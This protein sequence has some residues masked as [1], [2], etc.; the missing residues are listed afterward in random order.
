[1]TGGG[2]RLLA[3]TV[4]ARRER[5]VSPHALR[6]GLGVGKASMRVT[7]YVSDGA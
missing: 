2:A 6:A 4:F 3:V 5:I 7:D 1:M